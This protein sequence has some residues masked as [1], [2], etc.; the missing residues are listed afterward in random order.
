MQKIL[1]LITVLF[2]SNYTAADAIST[3]HTYN[4]SMVS[5]HRGS[6]STA[7]ENTLSSIRKAIIDGAGYAEIDVQETAD[8]LVVLMHDDNAK[9]TTGIDKNVWDLSSKE[10]GQASAG[11]WFSPSFHYE[12]V[13]TLEETVHTAKGKIKLNIEL[14]NNGHQK[15]LAEKT[16][17]ILQRKLFVNDCIVTSFDPALLK[18]VKKLDHRIRTGLIAGNKSEALANAVKSKDYDAISIAYTVIDKEFM[19]QAKENKKEVFAWT[20]NDPKAMSDML[21][22]G[23]DNIITNYPDRLIHLLKQS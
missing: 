2:A 4:H 22:L 19:L 7:P 12:K 3:S 23:V 11:A 20:V 13:P 21:K 15:L 8:G 1:M 10:L 6:S 14:K 9:R 16:V 17:E 5:A 18:K